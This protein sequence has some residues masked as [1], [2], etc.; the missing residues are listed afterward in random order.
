[1]SSVRDRAQV[2]AAKSLEPGCLHPPPP[3]TGPSEVRPPPPHPPALRSSS[4]CRPS[5]RKWT[6]AARLPPGLTGQRE[7]GEG[8]GAQGSHLGAFLLPASPAP[9][10]A[11]RSLPSGGLG[12]P[13]PPDSGTSSA[14]AHR[15]LGKDRGCPGHGP[16]SCP[17]TSQT[18]VHY[19]ALK[20]QVPRTRPS[21]PRFLEA[22][23]PRAPPRTT[24]SSGWSRR[25]RPNRGLDLLRGVSVLATRGS[26]GPCGQP[27]SGDHRS[28]PAAS[29]LGG[30]GQAGLTWSAWEPGPAGH[31][32]GGPRAARTPPQ[33]SFG[34]ARPAP[35]RGRGTAHPHLFV[36][37]PTASA[38][39]G[40]SRKRICNS[41]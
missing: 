15:G 24:L 37:A 9:G 17:H 3:R 11:V 22:P 32:P 6:E 1:M 29:A 26:Q 7:R 25:P 27:A 19:E 10:E 34:S 20:P 28:V 13:L 35:A 12:R 4:G 8:C 38:C 16:F 21:C 39:T 41:T 18:L 14:A 40:P 23:P 33:G 36:P 2:A 5:W 31:S 30:R